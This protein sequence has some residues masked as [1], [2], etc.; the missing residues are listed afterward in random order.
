MALAGRWER[1]GDAMSITALRSTLAG[2]NKVQPDPPAREPLIEVEFIKNG[3]V[4]GWSAESIAGPRAG[5][6]GAETKA[7]AI[8]SAAMILGLVREKGGAG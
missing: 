1:E 8:A 6:L 4:I 3:P 2:S 5:V 7:G